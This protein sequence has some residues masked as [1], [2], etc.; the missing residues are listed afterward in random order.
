MAELVRNPKLMQKAQD[1]LR[2]KLEGK[3]IVTEDDLVGP[4]K[5]IKLVIKETLR[6]HPVVPMLLPRECR[7]SCKIMG[8]DIPKGEYSG[9]CE[10]LGHQ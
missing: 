6:V 3:P 9:V 4:L 7:E 2:N 10:C 1:E 5:Y 8:Y